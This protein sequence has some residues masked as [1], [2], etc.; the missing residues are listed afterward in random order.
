M[1]AHFTVIG[2]AALAGL[3]TFSTPVRA[4]ACS[5]DLTQDLNCNGIEGKVTVWLRTKNWVGPWDAP[6]APGRIKV[7]VNG[8][9]LAHEFGATGKDWAWEKGGTVEVKGSLQIGLQR[10]RRINDKHAAC[11]QTWSDNFTLGIG[12]QFA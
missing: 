8:Q 5:Q 9:K 3:F 6:G 1:N 10:V 12:C 11:R 4:Q 7:S 2:V